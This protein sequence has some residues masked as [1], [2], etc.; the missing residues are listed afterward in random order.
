MNTSM[1]LLSEINVPICSII[2]YRRTN[3]GFYGKIRFTSCEE[4]GTIELVKHTF[5]HRVTVDEGVLFYL[6]GDLK[7]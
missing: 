4:S 1:G 5:C 6:V 2:E 7:L 3:Y